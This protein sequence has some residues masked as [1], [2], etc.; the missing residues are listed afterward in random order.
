MPSR[1]E[2]G[3]GEQAEDDRRGPAQPAGLDDRVDDAA[4]HQ[5][6]QG[7]A[8]RVEPA[9]PGG[10]GLGHE[11]RGAHDRGGHD[12]H[13]D[14]EDGAPAEAVDQGAAEDRA[15][16]QRQAGHRAEHADGPGPL[17]R[18]GE[19]GGDD[20]HRHRVEHRAPDGLQRTRRDQPADARRQAAQQRAEAEGGQADLED[21]P[22]ADPV[23]GGPGQHQEAGQ[24]QGVRVNRPLQAGHRGVQVT[25]DRRQRDVDDGDVH[26]HDD[27]AGAADRE[28][29]EP[30][31]LAEPAGRGL[32]PRSLAHDPDARI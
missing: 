29:E 6:H 10:A 22:A 5:D 20:R 3:D 26:H 30:A 9:R 21:A 1:A 23:G 31:A 11:Q 18:V 27:D 19:R 14:P 15:Q 32:R 25:P 17:G 28:H 2:H 7:L 13:V 24:H 8:H 16:R 12:R 4:Q